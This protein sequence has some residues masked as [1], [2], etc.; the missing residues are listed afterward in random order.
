MDDQ[1]TLKETDYRLQVLCGAKES[2]AHMTQSGSADK[3]QQKT[4][5]LHTCIQRKKINQEK[6]CVCD[7][8][9]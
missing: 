3:M 8:A 7:G 2:A 9:F 6:L 1:T 5:L 4:L